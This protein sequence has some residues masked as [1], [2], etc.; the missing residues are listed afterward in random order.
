MASRRTQARLA[1]LWQFPLLL[2]SVALFGV[3]AYLFIDPRPGPS[4]D[5]KIDVARKFLD[6]ERA[7]ASL[8]QLNKLLA[9]EKL[10]TEHEG[11]IHLMLAES[12]EMGQRQL[13]ISIPANHK[14]II[15][16]T[17]L[18]M[19]RGAK[20]DSAGFRRLGES[21]ESLAK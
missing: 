15:E 14:R 13:K 8:A 19:S 7:D 17:R 20:L 3:A 2:I 11:K 9:T 5:E 6:Q 1:Q 18:A 10:D 4:I 16:Q 12:L 21:Y